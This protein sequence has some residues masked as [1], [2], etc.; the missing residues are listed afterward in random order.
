M[1]VTN[2]MVTNNFLTNLNRN[3]KEVAKLQSQLSSGKVIERPSDDPIAVSK[4][5]NLTT[6]IGKN[7]QYQSNME[8]A[9]AWNSL[10]DS[11][12]DNI[13]NTMQR[14]RELTVQ[15]ANGSFSDTERSGIKAEVEQLT[16]QIMQDGNTMYGGRYILAGNNNKTAPFKLES[17]ELKYSG[18]S[19]KMKMEVST[20]LTV[21]INT[22][23]SELMGSGNSLSDM[24]KELKSALESGDATKL[25]KDV[26][27]KI[28]DNIDNVLNLRAKVGAKVNR[29]ESIFQK[30]EADNLNMKTIL[31]ENQDVDVAEKIMEYMAMENVY[32]TT[33]SAGAKAIQHSLLDYLR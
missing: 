32:Q 25:S 5:M 26:L 15:A 23:G 1:R 30:N 12:L 7:E 6:A 11:T 21:G 22:S 27:G 3:A 10:T 17:G 31:S 14:L 2:K 18:D 20:G 19:G 13:G 16:E 28:D 4:I 33:L 24:L 8:D 29:F 9:I